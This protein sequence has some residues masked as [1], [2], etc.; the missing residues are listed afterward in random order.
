MAIRKPL[1]ARVIGAV[2][3]ACFGFGG[4][5]EAAAACKAPEGGAESAPMFSPPLGEIV[6]GRGRLP[7]FSAPDFHCSIAG[8][9]V[10]PNDSLI[11]YAATRDGWTS[12]MY[13]NPTTGAVVSGWVR[14]NRLKATGTMGPSQ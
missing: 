5:V 3:F 2:L 9:F 1:V 10:V 13:D 6:V 14:S 11:A 4:V 7:F 12:V 8:V